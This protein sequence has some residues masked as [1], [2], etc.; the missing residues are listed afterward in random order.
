[1]AI[2]VMNRSRI[3]FAETRDL[4]EDPQ[5]PGGL[6]AIRDNL[7]AVIRDSEE[8]IGF[9]APSAPTI[10][11]L[12]QQPILA[13]WQD[14]ATAAAA[15]PATL[16]INGAPANV[17]I[18]SGGDP[19]LDATLTQN[20]AWFSKAPQ[21]QLA[22]RA[23]RGNLSVGLFMTTAPEGCAPG[24]YPRGGQNNAVVERSTLGL[25]PGF[26]NRFLG[27]IILVAV[28]A[29]FILP[30]VIAGTWARLPEEAPKRAEIINL[31]K[32]VTAKEGELIA[33]LEAHK[34]PTSETAQTV[35]ETELKLQTATESLAKASA[36]Y[37]NL[38]VEWVVA[39]L[40]LL[41]LLA[42]ISW[43]LKR[44][45]LGFMVDE[46]GRMS[47]ARFQFVAWML[48]ILGSYW[49]AAAW[50]IGTGYGYANGD[51]PLPK[52]S[53]NLWI[54]LG[55][56]VTSPLV[57]ALIL[58]V[59]EGGGDTKP[60]GGG[61]NT[62][63]VGKNLPPQAPANSVAERG[64]IDVRTRPGTSSFLDMFTGEEITNRASV[65]I[66]RVQQFVFTLV[67]LFAYL[68][69]LATIFLKVT[70]HMPILALPDISP[71]IVGLLAISHASYLAAK[72]LP[73]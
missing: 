65:D 16:S 30:A 42:T 67:A 34:I 57:S 69:L 56:S 45:L 72:S 49:M 60:A 38:A 9:G 7:A 59:K 41:A 1:M 62:A 28:L 14:C 73:K 2:D 35:S 20:Y 43:G 18:F 50:N 4:T 19:L 23:K 24:R 22:G 36:G 17:V 44:E 58:S 31:K 61:N 48:V 71:Y 25:A 21:P 40:G 13:A 51:V 63:S 32:D 8:G 52:M 53:M 11:D 70:P 6:R 29:I 26:R 68:G 27:A 54:L 15:P 39:T 47:L 33:A 37:V 46:R 3:I 55:I 64:L 5:F 66:S 10:D 12:A